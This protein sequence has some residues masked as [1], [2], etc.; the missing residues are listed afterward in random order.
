M[1]KIVR[2][3]VIVS[4][5]IALVRLKLKLTRYTIGFVIKKVFLKKDSESKKTN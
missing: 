2:T 4:M 1:N 3:I 5:L